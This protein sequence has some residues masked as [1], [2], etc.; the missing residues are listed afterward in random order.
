[1]SVEIKGID[2]VIQRFDDLANV[3][4]LEQAV[5]QACALVEGAA[6][7]NAPK[8]TGALIRSIESK[9]ETNTDEIVGTVF[10]PLEYAPYVEFGTGK[11]A[12]KGGR[13]DI[14]W[15]YQDD[16]GDWH[17]TSGQE[18]QPFLRPALHDNR[19]RIK[20]ILKGGLND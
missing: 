15:R 4:G 10:T 1:M 7:Q 20:T 5:G 11:F 18:P 3:E 16:K 6:K 17:T 12:K 13:K 19:E 14:P 8:D 9:V 2:D